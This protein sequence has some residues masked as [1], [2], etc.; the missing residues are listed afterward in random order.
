MTDHPWRSPTRS[1]MIG[2]SLACVRTVLL[3]STSDKVSDITG[4]R[5]DV[6]VL[7]KASPLA[8]AQ[9]S[10]FPDKRS[11]YVLV[12]VLNTRSSNATYY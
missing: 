3:R 7:A 10:R 11:L 12:I 2:I 1:S 6:T 5:E 9:I 4:L 8:I